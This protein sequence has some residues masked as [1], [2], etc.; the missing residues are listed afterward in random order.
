MNR[1]G[2][3]TLRRL[4][5]KCGEAAIILGVGERTVRDLMDVGKLRY[6]RLAKGQRLIPAA[7][8][9][10]Y[11]AGDTEAGRKAKTDGKKPRKSERVIA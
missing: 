5:Y 4:A 6:V 1:T 8:I 3:D 11:L 7:A 9:D 2:G 10:E